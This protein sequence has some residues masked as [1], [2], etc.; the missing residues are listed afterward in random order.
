MK[1]LGV[2]IENKCNNLIINGAN[3]LRLINREID[4]I[5][6]GSTLRFLIPIALLTGDEVT[7]NGRGG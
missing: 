1:A 5:E 6:S 7:F 4:C 3:P 2:K